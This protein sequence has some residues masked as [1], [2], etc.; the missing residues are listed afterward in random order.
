VIITD[1]ETSSYVVLHT[2][3]ILYII[4]TDCH[5]NSGI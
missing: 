4:F 1:K 3:F 2:F 5:L